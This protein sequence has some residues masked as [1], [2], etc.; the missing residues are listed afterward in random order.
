MS[1][2]FVLR[3]DAI[4]VCTHEL[5]RVKLA[6]SQQ[7]CTIDGKPIQVQHNPVG[8][9]IIGCPNATISTRPCLKTLRATDGYSNFVRIDGKAI[10]LSTITGRTDGT[11][12]VYA[13]KVNDP[14]QTIVRSQS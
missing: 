11:G 4:V 6:P 7:W 2:P 9:P 3:S 5:G 10:C 8:R 1:S 14:G 13:Y 12:E